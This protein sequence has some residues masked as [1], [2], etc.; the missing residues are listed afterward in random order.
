MKNHFFR[1][2]L[3]FFVGCSQPD[4]PVEK[5][6][7]EINLRETVAE[8]ENLAAYLDVQTVTKGSETIY[9]FSFEIQGEGPSEQMVPETDNLICSFLNEQMMYG[10]SWPEDCAQ[11]G[12]Y[13]RYL[14][15]GSKS[16][17]F[18]M[19]VAISGKVK[20]RHPM[21]PFSGS[22]IVLENI[23]KIESCP[24][25]I[26]DKPGA[27]TLENRFWTFVGFMDQNGIVIS[28]PTCENPEIGI[29]FHDKLLSGTPIQDPDARTF[30]I[31]SAAYIR[32][33]QLFLV[34]RID[35]ENKLAISMAVDPSWMPPRPATAQT[36]NFA[37]LT[38]GIY[39]KFDSLRQIFKAMESVDF[40]ISGNKLELHNS[41]NDIR[42]LFV[43]N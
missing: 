12:Y 32:P 24:V 13:N 26:I 29:T 28:S 15:A 21:D 7:L 33:N 10:M 8:I 42:A 36:D 18:R 30:T 16:G 5:I 20:E 1:I 38:K 19:H 3:L 23:N 17:N 9:I 4:D 2:A 35:S 39:N 11:P 27:Y 34:Y 37:Y 41:S 43:T 40:V 6:P 31:E 22:P 25:E 14:H